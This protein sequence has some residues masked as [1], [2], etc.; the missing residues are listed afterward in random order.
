MI[1]AALPK[2]PFIK[3]LAN[4]IDMDDNS[5]GTGLLKKDERGWRI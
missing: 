1:R 5:L 4:D 2:E 3:I